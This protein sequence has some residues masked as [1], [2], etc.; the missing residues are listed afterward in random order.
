MKIIV[1]SLLAVLKF[2]FK[3]KKRKKERKKDSTSIGY[4]NKPCLLLHHCFHAKVRY[5]VGLCEVF[6]SVFLLLNKWELV[7]Y[8]FIIIY[9][10][11]YLLNMFYQMLLFLLRSDQ[12]MTQFKKQ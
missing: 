1:H 11:T 9:L 8:K 4:L 6:I 7:L 2:F 3:K 5:D 12:L 10:F